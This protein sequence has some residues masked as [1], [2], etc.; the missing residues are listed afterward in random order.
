MQVAHVL[1]CCREE[2][3]EGPGN[4]GAGSLPSLILSAFMCRAGG[5]MSSHG[6]LLF[7]AAF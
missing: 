4:Y 5:W 7:T 1:P 6:F 2:R 3:A